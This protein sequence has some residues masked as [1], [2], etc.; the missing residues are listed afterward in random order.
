[1]ISRRS[2]IMASASA[3]A[4]AG[5]FGAFAA[6]DARIKASPLPLRDV[7]LAPSIFLNA[8]ERNRDY[9]LSL[10]PDRL[11]HNFHRSAGL[12]PKAPVYG[13]WEK[14]GIAGHT[15]GH[16]LS[17]LSM[18]WAQT[19]DDRVKQ[20]IGYTVAEL[21]RCQAAHGD[22]YV[23]GTTVERDGEEVDGKIVF[24]EIRN[25]DIRT[26]G[27]DINGGWVP[28][29][30][31]HKIHAGLIDAW[32]LAG[33]EQA[34]PVMLGLAGYLATI[35][36]GLDDEQMQRLLA[37]EHG[38]LNESYANT[39]ALT[40][41]D[42]WLT[43]ADRIR[44]KAVLD[45]LAEGR[46]NLPG[47]HANTQIP[48]VIGLARL[49]ELTGETQ[50]AD[51]SRF[52][53]R[54][55]LDHHTY[56]IGGNSEREHFPPPDVIA[57]ALT[58]RTCEAC[59]TYNMMKLGRH[60]YGWSMDPG[61][62]D[63]YENMHINHIMA[64]QHPE[65]GMFVYFMPMRSG[66]RRTYSEPTESFWCCV[67]SGME[68]HAKH[69]D[70]AYWQS[71]DTLYTNLYMPSDVDWKMGGMSLSV[72]TDYPMSEDIA[73]TVNTA[74]SEERTLAFRLPGWCDAPS[75]AVNGDPVAVSAGGGYARI[76]RAWQTGDTITLTL[77][78]TLAVAPSPDE[79]NTV[80]FR[81]GPLVLA[82]N[83]GPGAQEMTELPPALVGDDVSAS[84]TP[85]AGSF[86]TYRMTNAKPAAVTLT[87][88][89]DQYEN[90][91]AVYFPTFSEDE[92]S[93]KSEEFR[94]EQA[95]KAALE[96]RTADVIYLG[97]MQPERDHDFRTNQS[98][99]IAFG[100]KNGRTAWWGV[101]NYIEFD[102]AVP[103][104]PAILQVLYWGEE[105]DKNFD[106]IVDGQ[107]IA[108]ERRKEP[109][110]PEF[111]AV[112]YPLPQELTAGKDKVAVRFETRGSDAPVYE[113]RILKAE[114]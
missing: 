12:E 77:P 43:V 103:D 14:R 84:L 67:G 13:G 74:P 95:A 99:V 93:T 73:F 104:G 7:T 26:S 32:Q 54:T 76:T 83:L 58:D 97:E 48:K 37:A 79:P 19:G 10:D 42:R 21:A 82:A 29:Y 57:G 66:S 68:S 62:F 78:M 44:H 81:H 39:Y 4:L 94:A 23:G 89:F 110:K 111:V 22:G 3:I 53:Y 51:T 112:D 109:G 107:L 38:G 98:D 106:V 45:P 70:S 47:L 91:A 50:K 88:F 20:A 86:A 16:Y 35:L 9:L 101:G 64:H 113:V 36:E 75:L 40:G 114:A 105:T 72:R 30:T 27:F 8:I 41:N 55:V 25:G 2:F 59:N 28:L 102:M 60:L 11:L 31:W 90:R 1:M 49:Y 63:D 18:L 56:A 6:T 46:N 15:L 65:T 69:G 92:W 24:E 34:E 52:F 17:G 108:N 80:T 33:N 96:A 61:L 85:V 87:P 71:A 5:S 100:G